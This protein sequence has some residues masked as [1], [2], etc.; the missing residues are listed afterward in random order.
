[1]ALGVSFEEAA[2][3]SLGGT[4]AE[5]VTNLL[6]H[7]EEQCRQPVALEDP[8][9]WARQALARVKELVGTG[10][11]HDAVATG[12]SGALGEWRKSRLSRALTLAAEQ[13]A[14]E[15]DQW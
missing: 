6:A 1:E 10:T 11:D 3:S 4:P 2:S 14:E 13:V 15:W 12:N 7:I 9:N 8:G 5:A